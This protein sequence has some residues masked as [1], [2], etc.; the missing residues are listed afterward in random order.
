MSGPADARRTPSRRSVLVSAARATA[1]LPLLAGAA[2]CSGQD[3]G[4][5]SGRPTG[6]GSPPSSSTPTSTAL[7]EAGELVWSDDFDGAAGTALDR[8]DWA[9]DLG[10]GGWGNGELQT[11]TDDV[12]NAALDG[13]G[14]LAITARL[15]SGTAGGSDQRWTS[16]RVTTFGLHTLS[17]GRVEVRAKVASGRGIWPAAWTLGQDIQT[18]GWPACGEV[19]VIEAVNDAGQCL[20]T[21]HGPDATGQRWYETVSTPQPAPLSEAFHTFAADV[22]DERVLFALDGVV[23]G[24]VERSALADG[25][26]WPFGGPQY[27]LLNVAVGGQ[28]PGPTDASTPTAATMLVDWVRLSR[29]A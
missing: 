5:G 19:D 22:D 27:L 16:A 18:V 2:A 25:R 11:Y 17:A 3:D 1:A 23:T 8:R 29:P 20:Q 14:N 28:L 26:R 21:V 24:S 4:G 7:P 12:A 9:Y 15:V 10:G 6:G 13:Q